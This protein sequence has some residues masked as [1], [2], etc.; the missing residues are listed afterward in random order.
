M[1]AA[2]IPHKRTLG[3]PI[4][5]R[6]TAIRVPKHVLTSKAKRRYRLILCPAFVKS[7]S[8]NADLTMTSQSDEPVSHFVFIEE[9][10]GGKD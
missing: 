10:E 1:R 5:N 6:P 7:D 8:S 3:M 4:A 9:N 2:N